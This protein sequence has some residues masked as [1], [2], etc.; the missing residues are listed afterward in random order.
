[1][2]KYI[3]ISNQSENVSRIALEKLGLSTKRN[4]PDTIGQFG[5]GIK[6]APIAA[7]RMGLD[8]IFTGQ[9][10]KGQYIL[11]YK[12][13]Q[14]DGVDCIVYDY[15]DYKK[16]SSFTVDAGVL[17][18]EDEFQI[19]REAIANAMDEAKT[20]G[21]TWSR[22]IVDAKDVVS[23]LN[24]FSVYITA[25]PSMME[26][27]NDHDKY[28]LENRKALYTNEPN[29]NKISF[30]KPFDKNTHVYHKQVMVYE[31]EEYTSMFDYEVQNIKLNEMRT[32]SDEWTMNYRIAQAICEC[33]DISIVKMIIQLSNSTK[34]Y[35]EFEFTGSMH[36]VDNAWH[37][38][39]TELYGEKCIMLT[40]DQSIN[41]A[42]VSFIKEKG[43]DFKMISSS[44][45][46]WVLKKAGV[47][48]ID[49]IAGEAINY[50]IDHDISNYPKL[51]KAIEIA[52][53]FEPGLL[54]LEKPIACFI[55]KQKDHYL[56]V[57]INPD[58][59]DKQILIDRNHALNG[60][61]NEIVATVVHEYDHYET[62]YSDGDVIGRKFRD[63]ADRRIGKLMTE[64]YKPLL[65]E[66][67]DEKVIL[68]VKN[69][70]EIGG[71]NYSIV[72]VN[73]INSKF[74]TIG[75]CVFKV[76]IDGNNYQENGCAEVSASG[77]VFTIALPGII[78]I[79]R[80][81]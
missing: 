78:S 62:G 50:D 21:T 49:S 54:Q 44:F 7:L 38:A 81:D 57:V 73:E 11:K 69:I 71:I 75:N 15:G 79:D 4:D 30:Y 10:D 67:V 66:L 48:T 43:L 39:W 37:E 32:V 45:F 51:I 72:S 20:S 6:Y 13:E 22:E 76:V 3:K 46:F 55:P 8:W 59:D 60:E 64:F 5:S 14:E 27:Y 63:L 17:S 26:I 2:S 31:N 68:D 41:Q 16:S 56:G 34:N 1:M 25:S 80:L 58:T 77:K 9:D 24:E 12:V 29:Y 61:L 28:F 65:V 35:V 42:Y 74:M 47:Q 23:N 33:N 53:R 40:P 52:A 36:D 70:A 18:W 19:Y